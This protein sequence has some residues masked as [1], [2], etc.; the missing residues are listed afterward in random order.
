PDEDYLTLYE[1]GRLTGEAKTLYETL[2]DGGAMNTIDLRR[3]TRMTAPGSDGRF[4]KAITDLQANFNILPVG[5]SDAGAWHYSFIYDLT[6]RRFPDLPDQAHAISERAA[7]RRLAA[8]YLAALGAV[9]PAQAARLFGWRPA[10][11]GQALDD[12]LADGLARKAALEGQ[13]G[14]WY[15]LS[16]LL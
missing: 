8:A 3:A 7:R 1:Q 12:L 10:E 2:L 9:Q 15:V 13:P 6:T 4:S 5:V 14:E 16:A 11:A